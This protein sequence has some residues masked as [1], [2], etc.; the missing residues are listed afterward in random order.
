MGK[1]QLHEPRF[2]FWERSNDHYGMPYCASIEMEYDEDEGL[3]FNQITNDWDDH[4]DNL[5]YYNP[6][7]I[8]SMHSP[9]ISNG[10]KIKEWYSIGKCGHN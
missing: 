7:N 4:T 10:D 1:L 2:P 3:I 5:F 9:F 6:R 8:D